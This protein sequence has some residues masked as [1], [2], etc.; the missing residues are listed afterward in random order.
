MKKSLIILALVAAASVA[1]AAQ[2]PVVAETGLPWTT[3]AD[4][5]LVTDN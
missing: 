1:S 4:G 5:K 2:V 3:G